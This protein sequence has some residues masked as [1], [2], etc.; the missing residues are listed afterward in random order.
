MRNISKRNTI[1]RPTEDVNVPADNVSYGTDPVV[2][3]TML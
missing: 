2:K 3:V 1:H